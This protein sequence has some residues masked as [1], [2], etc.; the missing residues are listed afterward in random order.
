MALAE[1]DDVPDDEEVTRELELF[2]DGELFFDLGL[3][4]GGKG[5]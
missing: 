3:G 1:A 5:A 2:D 4:P